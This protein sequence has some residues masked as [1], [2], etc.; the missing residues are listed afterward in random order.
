[1]QTK[2]DKKYR[3]ALDILE[4]FCKK[5]RTEKNNNIFSA[6]TS[7]CNSGIFNNRT[8]AEILLSI[9]DETY[10]YAIN[11][12]KK[13]PKQ[14]VLLNIFSGSG[15]LI[16]E[17]KRNNLLENIDTIYNI[18]NSIEMIE[19][20]KHIF[21]D[22]HIKYI[23]KDILS[24][25]GSKIKYNLA[26]CH[27]GIR[28]I[29]HEDYANFINILLEL[30]ENNKSKCII[31]EVDYRFI[32]EIEEILYKKDIA[33][34]NNKKTIRMHRNTTFY[35]SMLCY[36]INNDFKNTIDELSYSLNIKQ[37]EILKEISGYKSAEINI[38][39]F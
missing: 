3:L 36:N 7:I 35:L 25:K 16:Y 10:D 1:M 14:G 39:T 28:Y 22:H 23:C 13:Y 34:K 27:C 20:E 32:E 30:K 33:F 37:Y 26:I 4:K 17:L 21:N 19:F 2:L 15:R 24:M 5:H 11:E 18:D 6:Y 8:T 29:K 12:I 31:S 38:L 9:H